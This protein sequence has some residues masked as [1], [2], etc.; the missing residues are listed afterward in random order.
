[1]CDF[2]IDCVFL[3]R[4]ER[5]DDDG[6]VCGTAESS[7]YLYVTNTTAQSNFEL[8]VVRIIIIQ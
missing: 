5:N 3:V 7:V 1:M 8:S 6:N 4:D 2:R